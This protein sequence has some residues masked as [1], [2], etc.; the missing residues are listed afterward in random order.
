M[1]EHHTPFDSLREDLGQHGL[2]IERVG[3]HVS[4]VRNRGLIPLQTASV[5]GLQDALDQALDLTLPPP[6]E[7][8]VKLVQCLAS[9]RA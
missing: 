5:A 7:D 8:P 2:A 6:A 4:P 1:L 9:V 3:L